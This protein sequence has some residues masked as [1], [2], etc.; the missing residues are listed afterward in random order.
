MERCRHEESYEVCVVVEEVKILSVLYKNIGFLQKV[1]K[2][3]KVAFSFQCSY[4]SFN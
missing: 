1:I 2:I 4:A 3:F